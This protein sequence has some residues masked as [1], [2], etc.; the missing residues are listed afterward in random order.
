MTT[1]FEDP[2]TKEM[3]RFKRPIGLDGFSRVLGAYQTIINVLEGREPKYE[4]FTAWMLKQ[5][6]VEVD[7]VQRGVPRQ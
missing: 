2:K 4:E 1:S 7:E 6:Y 5:G 3:L